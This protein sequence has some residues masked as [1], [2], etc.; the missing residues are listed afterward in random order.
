MMPR[1]E[2]EQP[3]TYSG[4]GKNGIARTDAA[5]NVPASFPLASPVL[6]P[7]I[8]RHAVGHHPIGDSWGMTAVSASETPFI[9]VMERVPAMPPTITYMLPPELLLEEPTM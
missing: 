7:E 9:V 8:L 6:G 3:P 1:H 2:M 4:G 5:A